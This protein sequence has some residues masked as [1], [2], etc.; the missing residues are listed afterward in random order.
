MDF[1]FD[2]SDADGGDASDEEVVRQNSNSLAADEHDEV[3][4]LLFGGDCGGRP[5]RVEKQVEGQEVS[6][7]V[8]QQAAVS[9]DRPDS[10]RRGMNES[11]EDT[12]RC[13]TPDLAVSTNTPAM[14]EESVNIRHQGSLKRIPASSRNGEHSSTSRWPMYA[15]N[16]VNEEKESYPMIFDR[17]QYEFCYRLFAVLDTENASSLELECI[18][19]FVDKYCPVT[20]RRDDAM[21]SVNSSPTSKRATF[22]EIWNATISCEAGN[23]HILNGVNRI[24]LEGWLVF[25]R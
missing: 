20:S 11:Q 6:N 5:T 15:I 3:L 18:R 1:P 8:I 24:G 2:F 13:L 19:H 4:A 22:D 14:T 10:N 16:V 9:P 7:Q 23:H 21:S 12:G 17:Q 25:C